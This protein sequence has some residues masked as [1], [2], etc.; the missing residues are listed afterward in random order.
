M[1]F[2]KFPI[3]ILWKITNYLDIYTLNKI[4]LLSKL[5]YN[6][7][8]IEIKKRIFGMY[9]KNRE[10]NT[11]T[12]ESIVY[13]NTLYNL[14]NLEFGV[15]LCIINA[16]NHTEIPF[17]IN[18][19]NTFMNKE[20]YKCVR[21]GRMGTNTMT[22]LLYCSIR[23]NH[24]EYILSNSYHKSKRIIIHDKFLDFNKNYKYTNVVKKQY[25]TIEEELINNN[26]TEFTMIT[27][28]IL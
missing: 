7:S 9:N 27:Y 10:Q 24:I 23:I 20:K 1:L 26:D 19:I 13:K 18:I 5:Y 8:N 11:N 15:L 12:D 21:Y 2:E 14:S 25:N 6:I 16:I 22:I 28:S 17:S 3:D 4:K